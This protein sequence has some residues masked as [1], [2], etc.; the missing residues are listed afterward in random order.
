MGSNFQSCFLNSILRYNLRKSGEH[1][2]HIARSA[3]ME[4][5]EEKGGNM[6]HLS[7]VNPGPPNHRQLRQIKYPNLGRVIEIALQGPRVHPGDVQEALESMPQYIL[8]PAAT[9]PRSSRIA[10][11]PIRRRP[12][13]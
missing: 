8:L 11:L 1:G 7:P 4:G 9:P 6:R 3:H 12:C 13:G 10:L 5:A 2:T